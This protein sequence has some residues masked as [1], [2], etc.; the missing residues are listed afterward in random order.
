MVP[1]NRVPARFFQTKGGNEPVR[2]FL[3]VLM[4]AEKKIVG[5]DIAKVEYGWPIGMPTSRS[6]GGGLHE[7]RSD[8]VSRIGRVFFY[9]S[10]DEEMILLHAIVKKT[11]KTPAVDIALARARMVEH[12]LAS[13]PRRAKER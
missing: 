3:K 7:V 6:L 8:L 9:I 5:G 13:R 1:P 2:K 12:K 11:E 10:D 4:I